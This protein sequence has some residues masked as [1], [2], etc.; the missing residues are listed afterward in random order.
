MT[1]LGQFA[2][3]VWLLTGVYWG[4]EERWS[5]RFLLTAIIGLHLGLVD[6][7]VLQNQATGALFTALQEQSASGFYHASTIVIALIVFYLVVAV[8]RA[9]LDQTLQ[10]RWRR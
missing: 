5:A 6:V 8:L 2:R 9:Y 1:R 7:T 10:L 3:D 4:S